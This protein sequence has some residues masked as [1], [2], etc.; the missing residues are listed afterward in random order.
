[1]NVGGDDKPPD[2]DFLTNQVG[3]QLFPLGD[4]PHG[5]GYLPTTRMVH[6]C[7]CFHRSTPYAGTNRI[8][9]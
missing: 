2:G 8:R 6:L 3:R 5:V 4:E 9:L 1:M 7:P